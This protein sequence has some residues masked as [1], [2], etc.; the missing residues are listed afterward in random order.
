MRVFI[1]H[2]RS[3]EEYARRLARSIEE[4]SVRTWLDE[5]DL[6]AGESIGEAVGRELRQSEGVIFL[7]GPQSTPEQWQRYEWS[8]ALESAWS[9]PR[10]K[11]LIPVLLGEAV[12][13]P[14]LE[15]RHFI[16]VQSVADGWDAA[17]RQVVEVLQRD[18]CAG[19][20]AE[21][22]SADASDRW[23][24]RLNELQQGTN[25]LRTKSSSF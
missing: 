8:M 17:A 5:R 23:M 20:E 14:F 2:A 13:P 4:H 19:E 10:G 18:P 12:L 9:D 6:Q 16:R 1:S 15:H 22:D 21:Q 11:K 7:I 25:T 3:D 24:T